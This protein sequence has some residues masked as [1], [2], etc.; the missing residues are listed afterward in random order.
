[1]KIA[2]TWPQTSLLFL[3][4]GFLI[5]HS[6]CK[7]TTILELE[8]CLICIKTRVVIIALHKYNSSTGV[9]GNF[10]PSAEGCYIWSVWANVRE[11]KLLA[12]GIQ[13]AGGFPHLAEE[14]GERSLD[15]AGHVEAIIHLN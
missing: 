3:F 2:L 8:L 4:K 14:R 6:P 11:Q 5:H 7:E 1:M 9:G 12:R 15:T 13:P 10:F